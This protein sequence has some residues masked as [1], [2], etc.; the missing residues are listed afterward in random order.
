MLKSTKMSSDKSVGD[1]SV[2][3]VEKRNLQNQFELKR[4]IGIKLLNSTCGS[5]SRD[6]NQGW[7]RG[8]PSKER[9]FKKEKKQL[10]FL[11]EGIFYRN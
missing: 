2:F 7:V 11:P 1:T 9:K 4:V 10:I 8:F 5:Q 3:Q 6:W